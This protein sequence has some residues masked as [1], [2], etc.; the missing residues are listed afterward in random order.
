MTGLIS[1]QDVE[2]IL[3]VSARHVRRLR[4]K[5][6]L[7]G[8][9]ALRDKR[10]GRAMPKR[11]P[12][13]VIREIMH[14][15]QAR[16][17]EFNM[18]HFH[19]R[20][21]EEHT[22]KVSYSYLKRL[23]QT[24]GLAEKAPARGKYRRKRP[25]RPRTGMMLHMDGSTHAWLGKEHGE[26]DLIYMLDDASGE[27]LHGE[28]VPE[29]D[30]RSCLAGLRHVLA[31]RGL[32][33]ELYTDRGSHFGRTAKAG[34]PTEAGNVQFARVLRSLRIRAIYAQSPQARGRSERAFRTVQGRLPQELRDAG[35]DNWDDANVYL[36]DKFIPA[37]NRKF[38]VAPLEHQSAFMP[39]VGLDVE[40]ACALEHEVTVY[41]DNTIR[42]RKRCFQIAPHPSRPSFA[43][44]KVL[45]VE[46]L[47]GRIDL[48]YGPQTIARFDVNGT[49]IDAEAPVRL[50]ATPSA[51]L[52]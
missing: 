26:R 16:Y 22:I 6:V 1:W 46:Y 25:R 23:L 51:S 49:P 20:L 37:F 8:I 41:P 5:C 17:S 14:L 13:D 30:T 52:G 42:W 35:I 44:C 48:E 27:A 31:T 3:C 28:F 9:E 50:R 18:Q 19:D 21:S 33:S 47:D 36:R 4:A 38:T 24:T 11:I 45:L 12:D 39:L 2:G 32:F 29:E 10:A 7:E 15:R 34:G 43:K 40:R